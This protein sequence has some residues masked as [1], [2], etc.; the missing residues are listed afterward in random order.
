MKQILPK[1]S[2]G[3]HPAYILISDSQGIHLVFKFSVCGTLL[4]QPEKTNTIDS[5]G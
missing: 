5:R 1:P 2:E 3:T 4:W